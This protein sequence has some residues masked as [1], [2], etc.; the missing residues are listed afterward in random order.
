MRAGWPIT[1]TVKLNEDH[2][3]RYEDRL[4]VLLE[5]QKLQQRFVIVR[6]LRAI[7]GN[8]E[9]HELLKPQTPFVPKKRFA[10]QPETDV[11]AGIMPSTTRAI[12]YTVAL[13][14]ANIPQ[15]LLDSLLGG[16]FFEILGRVKRIHLPH[17]QA[18]DTYSRQFKTLLWVE[19][20]RMGYVDCITIIFSPY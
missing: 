8:K 16:S 5:D 6:R 3:G 4:E 1:G 20:Y 12:S 7:V 17:R 9:D 11:I 19:E 2:Y 14:K 15:G 10:R 18:S 13:G